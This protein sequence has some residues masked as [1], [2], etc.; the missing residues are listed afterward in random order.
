MF[1]RRMKWPQH[2]AWTKR[3]TLKGRKGH[4][5]HLGVGVRPLLRLIKENGLDF[6]V[7]FIWLRI[8][9]SEELL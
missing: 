5:K 4:L 8:G 6:W 2:V 9:T 1:S 7:R 3:E